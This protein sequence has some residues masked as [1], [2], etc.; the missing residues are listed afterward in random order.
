MVECRYGIYCAHLR[1]QGKCSM[2]HRK[3]HFHFLNLVA[4]AG[5]L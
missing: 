4:P 2:P 3:S 1:A 5:S